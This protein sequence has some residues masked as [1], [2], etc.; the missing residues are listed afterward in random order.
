MS[1]T[2][3]ILYKPFKDL[4]TYERLLM[5][6]IISLSEA[7]QVICFGNEYA[8]KMIGV[9]VP[10]ITRAITRLKSL[11]YITTFQPYGERRIIRLL[12]CPELEDINL[13]VCDLE[14]VEKS[15]TLPNQDDY[16]PSSQRLDPLIKLT[17]PLITE[18]TYNKEYNKEHNNDDD[19]SLGLFEESWKKDERF[20]RLIKQFPEDKRVSI[21]ETYDLYWTELPEDERVKA[22]NITPHYL[23][24]NIHSPHFIKK[25]L[26]YFQDRFW[27]KDTISISL[28]EKNKT[29]KP[30]SNP[31][32][33][34]DF[35][36]SMVDKLLEK[37][38]IQ[39][40]QKNN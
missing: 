23:Q 22:E 6:W 24:R 40:Q 10:T 20:V 28:Y 26:Y 4:S 9:S 27:N 38:K 2:P 5:S 19:E 17:T 29:I 21:S 14:G 1:K 35:E 18:I 3:F 16:P 12:N 30:L 36:M 39:E 11:K 34:T 15:S 13:E 25:I 7:K 32:T 31:K 33:R 8:A 37:K